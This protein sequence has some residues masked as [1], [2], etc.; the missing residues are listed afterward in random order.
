MIGPSERKRADMSHEIWRRVRRPF[1]YPACVSACCWEVYDA[2]QAGC[3]KCGKNHTCRT[4]SVDNTCPLILCDDR[5]RVCTITGYILP[6]VRHAH[7]EFS[8]T[9]TFI[10]R[11]QAATHDLDAEVYSIVASLLLGQRAALCRKQENSRQYIRLTQH[12]HKQL[13]IFKLTNPGKLP[14]VC[15]ILAQAIA[16]E[17]YWRFIE[18]ASE[19]LV[20]HCSRNITV[21]LLDLKSSNGKM[22]IGSRLQE[23]VCGMLY[24]LKHGLT[25]QNK[26]LLLAIPEVDRCLPHENKIEAYFGI[27]SKV[28]CMTENEV[29][30]IFRESYQS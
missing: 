24:M 17:K 11:P 5:T 25:F 21:C 30:L 20:K 6:E 9:T 19:D 13:R 4:N 16:Q 7:E 18:P 27:S 15:Q 23:L 28:I 1:R 26:V 14:N 2:N 22:I 8:D 29:K 12:L 3:L 10:E